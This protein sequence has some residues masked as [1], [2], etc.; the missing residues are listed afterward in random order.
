MV[1]VESEALPAFPAA[2][3]SRLSFPRGASRNATLADIPFLRQL[4]W[5]FRMEEMEPVPWPHEMKRAF[6][7]GQFNLQHRHYVSVFSNADFLILQDKRKP[8]GR[9]YVDTR[10]KRW[11]II[12]IGFLP[13]WR[14][15]G[16]GLAM[17][18][19]VQRQAQTSGASGV[20]LHVERR[21]IRAQALY[22]RLEFQEVEASDTH[23]GMQ[24]SAA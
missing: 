1:S 16:R 17:L 11:H 19:A 14:N 6:I 15:R 2:E 20:F 7:D 4:Y 21:N 3:S 8:I 5:S 12:D 13:E 22:R 18:K 24:W 23:I 9:L 10:A